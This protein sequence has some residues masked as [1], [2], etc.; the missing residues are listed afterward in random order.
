[1]DD[2]MIV[3]LSCRKLLSHNMLQKLGDHEKSIV[4]LALHEKD[5][6]REA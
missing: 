6:F 5:V 3:M 2:S 4:L 1:M